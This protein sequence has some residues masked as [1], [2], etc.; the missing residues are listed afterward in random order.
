M[1]LVICIRNLLTNKFAL[2]NFAFSPYYCHGSGDFVH[3]S[4]DF[5]LSGDFVHETGDVVHESGDF[6]DIF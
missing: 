1:I 5:L 2:W 4:G 6:L 3:D